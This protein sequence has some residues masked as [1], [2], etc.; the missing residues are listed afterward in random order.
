MFCFK[1]CGET[2][3]FQFLGSET[4]QCICSSSKWTHLDLPDTL[5]ALS[6]S[7]DPGLSDRLLVAAGDMAEDDA[8]LIEADP[9]SNPD[10]KKKKEKAERDLDKMKEAGATKTSGGGSAMDAQLRKRKAKKLT[11]EAMELDKEAV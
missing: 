1:M 10:I 8:D 7:V 4:Q 3:Q 11:K 6:L 5:L 2:V 9:L